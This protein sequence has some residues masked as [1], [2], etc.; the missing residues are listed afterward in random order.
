MNSIVLFLN[1]VTYH[2]RANAIAVI[3]EKRITG[4]RGNKIIIVHRRFS[5]ERNLKNEVSVIKPEHTCV[6]SQM[7]RNSDAEVVY[8]L[9]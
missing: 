9:Y 4:A 3:Q 2:N 6:I 8:N 7:F 5:F 1:I